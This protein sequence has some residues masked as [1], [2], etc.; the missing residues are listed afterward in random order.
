M[1]C[2]YSWSWPNNLPMKKNVLA[3][4]LGVTPNAVSKWGDY[5]PRYAIAYIE[6]Y[7][8]LEDVREQVREFGE[9]I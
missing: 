2:K 9:S 7:C 1:S 3:E 6:L 8:E 5:P 4:K